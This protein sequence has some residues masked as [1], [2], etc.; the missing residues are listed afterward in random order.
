MSHALVLGPLLRHVGETTATIW[1]E[2]ARSGL[3]EVRAV[4]RR[5]SAPTFGA[6][7][8]HY[9][10]VLVEDLEPGSVQDYQVALDDEVV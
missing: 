2:T 8:H 9:A 10:I 6:H 3:V 5:W 7:G 1:V 4:G